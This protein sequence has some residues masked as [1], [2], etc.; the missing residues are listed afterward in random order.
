MTANRYTRGQERRTQIAQ[1]RQL[2]ASG[3]P[4]LI[5]AGLAELVRRPG[6]T[7]GRRYAAGGANVLAGSVPPDRV[8]MVA[9]NH[10]LT[11]TPSYAYMVLDV[12]YDRALTDAARDRMRG[13]VH[14]LIA[15]VR[16]CGVAV[17]RVPSGGGHGRWANEH[18]WLVTGHHTLRLEHRQRLAELLRVRYPD[19]SAI[20]G[21]VDG[22]PAA[23][24]VRPP[25]SRHRSGW[26]PTL[27]RPD[28]ILEALAGPGPTAAGWAL[29]L[30]RLAPTSAVQAAGRPRPTAGAAAPAAWARHLL[31]CGPGPAANRSVEG[32][33]LI[34]HLL[35]RGWDPARITDRLVDSPAVDYLRD[36]L[37]RADLHTRV[38]ND[39]AR[40]AGK[41][42]R[43]P[44]PPI[45]AAVTAVAAHWDLIELPDGSRPRWLTQSGRAVLGALAAEA[46]RTG[47]LT[48]GADQRTI[49]VAA[50]VSART[51][52]RSYRRWADHGVL[53]LDLDV[54]GN[55]A[56]VTIEPTPLGRLL[57]RDLTATPDVHTPEG[58]RAHDA[59]AHR[60]SG[61]PSV[62][63]LLGS[64]ARRMWLQLERMGT[65]TAAELAQAL[66]WARVYARRILR[67][68]ECYGLVYEERG[69][70]VAASGPLVAELL[71]AAAVRLG[72][73]G[74]LA[75]RQ[76]RYI[77]ERAQWATMRDDGP[78]PPAVADVAHGRASRRQ[79]SS[80]SQL[81]LWR[82]SRPPD[83]GSVGIRGPSV[84]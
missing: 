73:G 76:R 2:V 41:H 61:S 72:T 19:L 50:G 80:V 79:G 6:N 23:Q 67:R 62:G 17:V 59:W 26:W 83:E 13:Q 70:W 46:A 65:V 44:R 58:L 31:E 22:P 71:D 29:L 84:A 51:V 69:A 78:A 35:S 34:G 82:R 56:A 12:D 25:G 3:E 63:A 28:E 21:L 32:C 18:V 37:G 5:A 57:P 15:L 60:P 20:G 4:A 68:L 81:L 40:I 36:R 77:D 33:R 47:H 27:E 38:R 16:P 52:G 43:A 45:P 1:A 24:Q 14:D 53:R 9:I 8:A 11:V 39:V 66:Q 55:I 30:D 49:A 75:E 7:H 64:A 42:R 74:V 10:P 48:I 54:D